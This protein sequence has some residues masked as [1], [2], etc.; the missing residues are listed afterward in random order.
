MMKFVVFFQDNEEFSGQ[1]RR[2]MAKHLAFLESN[3][4]KVESAGP[5]FQATGGAGAGGM[6]LVN[7]DGLEEVKK[8]IHDDPFWPTGLRKK[9]T[10][11][12]WRQ[13]F[14]DG[15]SLAAA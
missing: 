14:R 4:D 2:H 1:R 6:W 5:L 15:Q 11:L 8:L 12:E 3:A 9:A 10:I 7:A 13:V